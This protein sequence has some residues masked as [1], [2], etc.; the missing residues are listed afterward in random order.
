MS[1]HSLRVPWLPARRSR[2]NNDGELDP[3]LVAP[4]GV[5][6]RLRHRAA[7]RAPR[8]G[9]RALRR[10]A[11]P[12]ESAGRLDALLADGLGGFARSV[13]VEEAFDGKVLLGGLREDGRDRTN[14]GLVNAGAPGEGDVVLPDVRLAPGRVRQLDRVLRPAGLSAPHAFARVERVSGTA[15]FFAYA[16][17]NDEGSSDGSF[18]AAVPAGAGRGQRRLVVPSVVEAGSYTTDLFLA[19]AAPAA[20]ELRLEW[21]ATGLA[22]PT[23]SVVLPLAPPPG[24]QLLLD[25]FV[26]IRVTTPAAGA[27]GRYGVFLPAAHEEELAT[28]SV[29]FPV[30]QLACIARTNLA[31]LN[32][33]EP[34][35]GSASFRVDVWDGA[36]RELVV[37]VMRTSGTA[38]FLAYAVV[39]D[40]ARPGEGTGDGAVIGMRVETSP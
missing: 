31:I 35:A 25:D 20:K 26:G 36:A 8:P 7:R 3:R 27:P 1:V 17:V 10:P 28:G 18:L 2:R 14:L 32:A 30:S 6:D 34:G 9:R 13:A 22:T 5:P 16:V 12:Y 4:R 33:G 24:S 15:R 19:N 23:G 38:P 21:V 40:G 29:F 37:T 39:N 11:R